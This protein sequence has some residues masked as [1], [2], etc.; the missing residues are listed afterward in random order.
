[1]DPRSFPKLRA[2]V[3]SDPALNR[4]N[5]KKKVSVMLPIMATAKK[6]SFPVPL[7][8]W[9]FC[10]HLKVLNF[11]SSQTWSQLSYSHFLVTS[12]I[13]F[14]I[15]RMIF[16]IKENHIA[17][18]MW[19]RV[20]VNLHVQCWLGFQSRNSQTRGLTPLLPVATKHFC[21][22]TWTSWLSERISFARSIT[23]LLFWFFS[24]RLREVYQPKIIRSLINILNVKCMKSIQ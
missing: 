18:I 12:Q 19:E 22:C 11:F 14:L 2:R 21:C 15:T 16:I 9:Y 20:T 5:L 7:F 10:T 8:F 13:R 1:M 17:A 23:V 4:K 6:K 3:K 24:R